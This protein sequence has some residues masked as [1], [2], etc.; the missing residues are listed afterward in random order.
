M[1]T[2]KKVTLVTVCI[3]ITNLIS[4]KIPKETVEVSLQQGQEYAIELPANPSTGYS[5]NML[6][7]ASPRQ[8]FLELTKSEYIPSVQLPKIGGGGTQKLTFKGVKSTGSA[9]FGVY[10]YYGRPGSG[11]IAKIKELSVMIT[12]KKKNKS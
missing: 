11:E 6:V 10:L 4:A 5:W 2:W 8:R 9:R 1:I 7:S 3:L 12:P